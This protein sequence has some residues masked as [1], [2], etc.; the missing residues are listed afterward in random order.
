LKDQAEDPSLWAKTKDQF[1]AGLNPG[2][3]SAIAE[4]GKMRAETAREWIA[5][6]KQ[7]VQVIADN[8]AI[9]QRQEALNK[10]AGESLSKAAEIALSLPDKKKEFAASEKDAGDESA[11]KLAEDRAKALA[12]AHPE[13]GY[14]LN[15]QQ[16]IGAYAATPPVLEQQLA[17]LRSID[18]K[19][20]PP[21]SRGMNPPTPRPPS[22]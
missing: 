8:A 13:R 16:R 1:A 21:A 10:R 20:A 9:R 22:L 5:E 2:T 14:S 11:A 7:T 3:R 12:D 15:S 17:V 4:A 6:Y 19:T 18:A